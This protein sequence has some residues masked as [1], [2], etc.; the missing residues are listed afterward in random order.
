[1]TV[2]YK[3]KDGTEIKVGDVFGRLS[4]EGFH[5][6]KK[7]GGKRSRTYLLCKC[8]CGVLKTVAIHSLLTGVTKSCGCLKVELN[9]ISRSTHGLSHRTPIYD[10][11]QNMLKRCYSQNNQD[12]SNYGGRGV[13]VCERWKD[14]KNFFDDLQPTW[15]KGLSLDR[16]DVNGNY[17][18]LN[19][20]WVTSL[21]QGNNTRRNVRL[22]IKGETKTLAQWVRITGMKTHK[23][24]S[25]RLEQGWSHCAA[26]F[27]KARGGKVEETDLPDNFLGGFDEAK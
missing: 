19:C 23:T 12:Y 22:T 15:E 3:C 1:M 7:E 9:S 21:E 2:L 8:S 18:P 26:I 11:W 27:T 10:S 24:A 17:E 25:W 6:S 5:R 4:V 14:F 13:S 16:T 20:K